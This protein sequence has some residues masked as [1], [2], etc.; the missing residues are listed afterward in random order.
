MEFCWLYIKFILGEMCCLVS[1]LLKNVKSGCWSIWNEI[2]KNPS[3][4]IEYTNKGLAMKKGKH[5][6]LVLSLPV[7]YFNSHYSI[8]VLQDLNVYEMLSNW[9]CYFRDDG[10][11]GLKFYTD[12]DY[13]FDLWRQEMLKD[14]ERMMH[15]KGKKVREREK[16]SKYN[17]LSGGSW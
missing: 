13:F 4:W 3:H 14:T 2:Q 9:T 12:P 10:K 1:S 16:P 7:I 8:K 5:G 6:E 15:D 17:L 11:D